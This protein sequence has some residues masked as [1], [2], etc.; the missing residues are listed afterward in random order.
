[1]KKGY[2]PKTLTKRGT[3][4]FPDDE[5]FDIHVVVGINGTA[6]HDVCV[7]YFNIFTITV[8]EQ[9]MPNGL[10]YKHSRSEKPNVMVPGTYR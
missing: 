6:Q 10:C 1:M 7:H 2:T 4:L 5:V 9:P 3:L 8:S